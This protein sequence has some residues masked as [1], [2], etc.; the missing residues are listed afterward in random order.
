M[1]VRAG[2]PV[3]WRP[4]GSIE[5]GGAFPRVIRQGGTGSWMEGGAEAGGGIGSTWTRVACE[6]SNFPLISALICCPPS[7][8]SHVH[9]M[10][11]E[12]RRVEDSALA[13]LSGSETTLRC[14]T[15]DCTGDSLG[16]WKQLVI[17]AP[18]LSCCAKLTHFTA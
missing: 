15:H 9:N 8:D 14:D 17:M 7:N 11:D 3:P 4:C 12:L 2:G 1:E 10:P 16:G 6:L 5:W 18:W 13:H